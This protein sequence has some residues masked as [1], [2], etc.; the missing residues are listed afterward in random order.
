MT[1]AG[2]LQPA[3]LGVSKG[4]SSA[5]TFA[6]PS[7]SPGRW[8]P[9]L[10]HGDMSLR[11]VRMKHQM[12]GI[13]IMLRR[14]GS[15]S[16]R[17]QFTR[18]GPLSPRPS[19]YQAHRQVRPRE[20]VGPERRGPRGQAVGTGPVGG[21]SPNAPRAAP[22]HRGGAAAESAP[23]RARGSGRRGRGAAWASGL[24]APQLRHAPPSRVGLAGVGWGRGLPGRGSAHLPAR[25]ASLGGTPAARRPRAGVQAMEPGLERGPEPR[26][27]CAGGLG[28]TQ[29]TLE[30]GQAGA[31]GWRGAEGGSTGHPALRLHALEACKPSSPAGSSRSSWSGLR[32][33]GCWLSTGQEGGGKS[34]AARL[35]EEEEPL[36]SSAP[37]TQ[38]APS[39]DVPLSCA[40]VGEKQ[41][42]E[43]PGEGAGAGAGRACQR[44]GSEALHKDRT[45]ALP[46]PQPQG[47]GQPLPVREGK[48]GKRS[49]SPIPGKQKKPVGLASAASPSVANPARATYNP[50]PCGSGRGSCHLANLLSTLAQNNQNPDQKK[51][52]LEVTCQGQKKKRTLYRSDQLE[53]LERVFQEDHYPDS[54]K[55][56]EI[57]QTVGVTP[58]R[59]MVWFQNRRAKWRKVEKMHGKESKDTPA[60]PAPAPASNQ[61]SSAAE[62]PPAVPVDPEPGTFPQDPPLD[63]LPEPA[64]LLTSDQTL[65]PAQQSEGARGVAV[66]PPLFSPPP[67]RRA[68]L[69][70]PLGPIHN[71]QLMSLLLDTPG[72]DSSLKDGP[73]GSWGTSITPPPTCSYLEELEP[74]DYQPSSQPG[75]F[76]FSQAP[77]TQLF[78]HPQPQFPYLHP[79]PF[80]MPS[81]LTPPLPE[82]SLF[83]LSC[84]PSG[85]TSPGYFPG[86]ASGQNLLQPPAGNVGT[87]PWSDPCLPDL[88]FPG[89]FCPPALGAPP[90]GDGYFLDLFAAPY[91]QASSRQ[92]SPGPARL[93]E[94][95]R[96][97][98]GPLL[99]KAPEELPAAAVELPSAPEEGRQEDKKS[100]GP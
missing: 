10:C 94:G 86:P 38:E 44:P 2:N 37:H 78:Q 88:P 84:G 47:E 93:P 7:V 48:P 87:V 28:R 55:R 97:G 46:R 36:Q 96:P 25:E 89:P 32:W 82:D 90:G 13:L 41:P 4:S 69:P 15:R 70:F 31:G 95:S 60:S 26:G 62:L 72:S 91:A 67:V 66:T 19:R 14:S 17:P 20:L 27:E 42:S 53:E 74:Q 22:T 100:H 76:Q 24:G 3:F 49:C 57:A 77:Q 21:P 58:Q 56:R 83:T 6:A 8:H 23:A 9:Q 85:G 51:R 40:V 59:I 63:P 73:C 92:A 50:V 29:A 52:S 65:A 18:K 45:L 1:I 5:E 54:D 16:R 11:G 34:L 99:S 71:P 30:P 33:G 81:S 43:A 12:P 68:N 75:L 98:A 39:E 64:M 61:G 79:F 80:H 35:E